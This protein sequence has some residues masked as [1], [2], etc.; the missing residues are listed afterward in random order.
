M[1]NTFFNNILSNPDN[2]RV[3]VENDDLNDMKEDDHRQQQPSTESMEPPDLYDTPDMDG[4]NVEENIQSLFCGYH[5]KLRNLQTVLFQDSINHA[6]E[7]SNF[8]SE[9]HEIIQ[10]ASQKI[11]SINQITS[12]FVTTTENLKENILSSK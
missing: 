10:L 5:T 8:N 9:C 11:C 12:H 1:S 4:L 2:S 6:T 3:K 7:L